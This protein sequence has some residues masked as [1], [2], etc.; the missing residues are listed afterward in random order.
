MW[1]F[2]NLGQFDHIN[3]MITVSV[4]KLSG[5]PFSTFVLKKTIFFSFSITFG[6]GA[7]PQ[8][9]WGSRYHPIKISL[10]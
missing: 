1:D 4:I 5:S 10:I 2:I 6:F 3:R 9:H 8:S 7:P